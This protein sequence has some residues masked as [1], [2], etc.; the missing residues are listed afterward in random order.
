MVAHGTP[1]LGPVTHAG[2]GALCPAYDRGCYG[3]FGPMETPNTASLTRQLAGARRWDDAAVERVFRTFNVARP[4]RRHEHTMTERRTKTIKTDYLARVEGEGAMLV[5]IARRRGRGGEAQDLRAAALLRGVP[6]RPR[7]HRGARH[8]RAHLRHLPGRLPD[9]LRARD[10]GGLRRRGRRAAARAAPAPLLRRVDR[11]PRAPR[12]HAPRAR[13]PR[14]RRARSS[15]RA[16]TRARRERARAEE[17]RQRADDASSAGAR[18]TRS[19][20]ASAA[21]TARRASAS[22]RR[23]CEKLEWAR[24]IALEA[25]RSPPSFDFPDYEQDYEFVA[26]RA[27]GRV[28]DRPR[29]ASSRTAG[30]DIAVAEYDEHFV[31]EHVE[32][33]NALHSTAA[34]SAAPTSSGRSR[35]TRSPTTGSRRSRARRRRRSGSAPSERNPF[36]SIVVRCRRDRLRGRRGAAADR[37]VRGAGRAVRRGRAARGRRPRRHRG[38]ARHP[39][40]PLRDRRRRARSST[41]RSCRRPRRTRRTI[42]EDLRGV[43]ERSLDLPD[44]ELAHPLRA[45]DPQ[46]RPVHLL[47][48]ALP[49][50][51]GRASLKVVGVGNRWR[52]DD[53]AGL[54]VA[55]LPRG[56]AAG[57]ASRCSSARASRRR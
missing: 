53:A 22:W 40:P 27:A 33:S 57:R 38:A 44:D 3:C 13:L 30:L 54:D 39:L 28:P 6:A 31:E 26:P 5:R 10:G 23:S 49:E 46:L 9:E 48:D 8:H 47:R 24:E 32:R 45:D 29:R 11:E 18:S 2:C 21:C 14:L 52:G 7:V 51:R 37:R 34:P 43:V 56:H 17:D 20:S 15:W 16:T 41:R 36:R 55:R 42:E 35:A 12:L 25:V 4:S 19:T 1:C 50:A